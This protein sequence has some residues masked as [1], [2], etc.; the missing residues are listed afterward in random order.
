MKRLKLF[1]IVCVLAS[2]VGVIGLGVEIFTNNLKNHD[3]L[4]FFACITLAG[5]LGSAISALILLKKS[6]L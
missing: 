4:T 3:V 1:R 5:L 2:I 6:R